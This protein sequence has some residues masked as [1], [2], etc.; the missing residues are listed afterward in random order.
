MD[1]ALGLGRGGKRVEVHDSKGLHCS[2]QTLKG[3][4]D[5]NPGRKEESSGDS[6]GVL[7]EDLSRP[8][9]D[10]GRNTGAKGHSDE[11]SDGHAGLSFGQWRKGHACYKVAKNLGH[12]VFLI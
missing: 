5:D 9:Q 10:V 6:L 7:R 2:E 11:V 4:S 1:V 8:E 3:G 12:I